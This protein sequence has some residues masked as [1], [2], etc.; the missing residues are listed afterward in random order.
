[1]FIKV[2]PRA[3]LV[4]S[5]LSLVLFSWASIAQ[6]SRCRER[7]CLEPFCSYARAVIASLWHHHSPWP[8]PGKNRSTVTWSEGVTALALLAGLQLIVAWIAAKWPRARAFF[9]SEPTLLL[10][11]GQVRHEALRRHQRP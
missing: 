1:M 10:A 8:R 2:G 11:D 3:R 6:S 5:W 4:C 9:T 7:G